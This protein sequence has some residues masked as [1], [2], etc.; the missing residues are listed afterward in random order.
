MYFH[1]YSAHVWLQLCDSLIWKESKYILLRSILLDSDHM[2][3]E[4]VFCPSWVTC[5]ILT[6][7]SRNG[8]KKKTTREVEDE[9]LWMC[10]KNTSFEQVFSHRCLLYLIKT[11]WILGQLH[12]ELQSANL[13]GKRVHSKDQP[14]PVLH[15]SLLPAWKAKSPSILWS[16][17]SLH[18][19][20]WV[21][22]L[23]WWIPSWSTLAPCKL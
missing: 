19:L 20:L 1:Q 3:N 23:Q 15:I 11:L 2:D 18:D 12:C 9:I 17:D 8:S 6:L 5:L 21:G 4:L 14:H 7:A 16:P 10:Q 22:S 13:L